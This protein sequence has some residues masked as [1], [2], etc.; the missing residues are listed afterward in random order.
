[1]ADRV[2][3]I[4]DG[5]VAAEAV[6]TDEGGGGTIVVGRGGWLRLPEEYLRR[7]GIVPM[8]PLGSSTTKSSF[9]PP[10]LWT[11]CQAR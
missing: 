1:M 11:R 5:R 3:T 4:R 10:G 6:R 7:A 9:G 8:R 2:V